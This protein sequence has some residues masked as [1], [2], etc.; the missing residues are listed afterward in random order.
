MYGDWAQYR[1]R[2]AIGVKRRGDEGAVTHV[3]CRCCVGQPTCC[4]EDGPEHRRWRNRHARP[5]KMPGK[6]TMQ[7]AAA[8]WAAR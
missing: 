1:R 8:T 3:V 6:T 7:A 4:P 5:G 2:V